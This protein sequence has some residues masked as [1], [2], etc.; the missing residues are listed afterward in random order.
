MIFFKLS[1]YNKRTSFLGRSLFMSQ[2]EY[3]GIGQSSLFKRVK[4]AAGIHPPCWWSKRGVA[5]KGK[6]NGGKFPH[7]CKNK[8]GYW[9]QKKD[10][11]LTQLHYRLSRAISILQKHTKFKLAFQKLCWENVL[12]PQIN[13]GHNTNFSFDI[14]ICE[15]WL[16]FVILKD[17]SLS[18]IGQIYRL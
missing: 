8:G 18:M 11:T 9:M 6:D 15:D 12:F 5:S 4:T 16:R 10:Y 7:R 1:I 14:W 2:R 17:H 3:A 13:P